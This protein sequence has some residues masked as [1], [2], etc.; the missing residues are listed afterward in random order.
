M[1]EATRAQVGKLVADLAPDAFAGVLLAE[2]VT[3]WRETANAYTASQA[4]FAYDGYRQLKL[5]SV[6]NTTSELFRELCEFAPGA[7]Q[8]DAVG[9]LVNQWARRSGVLPPRQNSGLTG[10]AEDAAQWTRFLRRFDIDF[11]RRRLRFVVQNLNRLYSRLGDGELEGLSAERLD[12][13]KAQLYRQLDAIRIET[14]GR[15]PDPATL[16]LK[17]ALKNF[18]LKA[19]ESDM[20]AGAELT[21]QQEE[22]LDDA[23]SNLAEH[24]DLAG[25]DAS[26]DMLFAE[27]S[28]E[29]LPETVTRELLT[30]YI[31]FAFWDVLTF[32]ITSW[33]DLGEFDEIRIDRISPDDATSIRGGGA[34]ATLKGIEFGHF[35]AFFSRLH[36]ENDY[37]WGRLHGAERMIDLL[38]DAASHEDAT[39]DLDRRALKKTIFNTIL[40]AE[41]G[42]LKASGA[43]IATV[44]AEIAAL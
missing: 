34:A 9:Y 2:R 6:L 7:W 15:V 29:D 8:A 38:Y 13:I 19:F 44:R 43:L 40:E 18:D 31:G 1:I 42:H 20:E 24:L 25:F 10:A 35:G 28:A 11:R 26:A 39:D 12:R 16:S 37:L 23:L 36:R 17:A 30:A 32:S 41:A 4:G 22:T 21:S 14:G 5:L 27:I 3:A 33:R